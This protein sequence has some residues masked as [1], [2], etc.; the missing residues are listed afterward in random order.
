MNEDL[1]KQGKDKKEM[2]VRKGCFRGA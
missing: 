2:K 1:V